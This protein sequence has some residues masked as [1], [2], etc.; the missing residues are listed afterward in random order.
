MSTFVIYSQ[1]LFRSFTAMYKA[2]FPFHF[3]LCNRNWVSRSA[4]TCVIHPRLI[5][6]QVG[7]FTFRRYAGYDAVMDVLGL[8]DAG[9]IF[10]EFSWMFNQEA[11][12]GRICGADVPL[13]PHPA[14]VISGRIQSPPLLEQISVSIVQ[15]CCVR[16]SYH[17]GG[18]SAVA[19]AKSAI[20]ESC[21]EIFIVII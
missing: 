15:S 11:L 18:L 6:F 1:L 21:K 13:I 9:L 16:C 14:A 5:P 12:L 4:F 8:A 2:K 17:A 19:K 7:S 20:K 10:T 3:C